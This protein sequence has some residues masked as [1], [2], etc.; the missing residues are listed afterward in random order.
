MPSNT[1]TMDALLLDVY[2]P[3]IREEMNDAVPELEMFEKADDLQFEGRQAIIA[4]HLNRNR[5]SGF[6]P[7]GGLPPTAGQQQIEN[8]RVPI[9]YQYGQYSATEQI[10]KASRSNKGSFARELKYGMDRLVQDMR[11]EKSFAMWG[12]GM[13]VRALINGS[14]SSTTQTVDAPGGVAGATNGTRFLNVGD[15]VGFVNPVTGAVALTTEHEIT[16][17]PAAGTTFVMSPTASTTDNHWVVK[18]RRQSGTLTIGDTDYAKVPMGMLAHVD[19]STYAALYFG[20]SRTTYPILQST[21]I[22]S[23][24][25]LSG[26]VLQRG[27]DV[28]LERSGGIAKYMLLQPHTLRSYLTISE[29]DRRYT[30]GDLMN[31]DVGTNAAK[32]SWDTGITFGGISLKRC[33]D[34]PYGMIMA[35]D[36]SSCRR[37][38]QD[39]GSWQDRDGSV[40]SRSTTAVDTNDATYRVWDNFIMENPNQAV[41]WDG[42][43]STVVVAHRV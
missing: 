38:V 20:L 2:Q 42:V 13:G 15:W 33:I 4:A 43:T 40:F 36:P 37:V 5:G 6:A 21:V 9:R 14:A 16:S 7:E 34:M 39:E 31:P 17:V 30:G 28:M 12:W 3:G 32:K 41:R 35:L 24:G 27:L 26:D 23:V 18:T 19:D 10:I 29:N 25:A 11:V 22:S 1:S 8:F